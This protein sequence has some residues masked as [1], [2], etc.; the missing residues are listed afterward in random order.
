MS[1]S[2]THEDAPIIIDILKDKM[3]AG[4]MITVYRR[5]HDRAGEHDIEEVG[6]LWK[7]KCVCVRNT[8]QFI[9]IELYITVARRQ[10]PEYLGMQ[11]IAKMKLHKLSEGH[12][13]LYI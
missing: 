6:R 11:M 5:I 13:A 2:D 9:G 12:W 3:E 1:T 4:E 10:N 8:Q 7:V